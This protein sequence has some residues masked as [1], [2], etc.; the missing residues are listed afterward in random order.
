M[1]L[2]EKIDKSVGLVALCVLIRPHLFF[3]LI[4]TYTQDKRHSSTLLVGSL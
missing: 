2:R 1:G 4:K 3:V